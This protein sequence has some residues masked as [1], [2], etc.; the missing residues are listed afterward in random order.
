MRPPRSTTD[1]RYGTSDGFRR[2]IRYKTSSDGDWSYVDLSAATAVHVYLINV[3]GT[4]AFTFEGVGDDAA[5][6]TLGASGSLVFQAAA[7]TFTVADIGVYNLWVKVVNSDWAAGKVFV[8]PVGIR[9]L[10]ID[11]S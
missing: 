2:T 4:V 5:L 10:N 3:N 8:S 7:D 6:F 11:V 9:I 1:L